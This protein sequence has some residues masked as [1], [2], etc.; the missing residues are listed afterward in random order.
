MDLTNEAAVGGS[1][2]T[3]IAVAPAPHGEMSL[4]AREAARNLAKWR[5]NREKQGLPQASQ[6]TEEGEGGEL[7]SCA[8]EA[9]EHTDAGEHGASIEETAITEQADGSLRIEPPSSWSEQDKELFVSLPRA[10]QERLAE[11]ECSRASEL[12][13]QRN[14]VEAD[15]A[16]L[17]EARQQYE[18]T[19]P[20][21]LASLQGQQ[22]SEFSDI[23]TPA[24]IER[25]AREDQPRF[26][27]WNLHQQQVA[28]VTRQ[29]LGAQ[30]RQASE[31]QR[32][33][34]DFAKRQDDL[35]KDKVPQMADPAEVAKLQSAA[36][37]VL[38]DHGFEEA[39][40]AASWHGQKDFSLRDHR[41]QLLVRDAILWREAKAKAKAAVAKPLPPVQRPGT[42]Q[43]KGA[44][45]EA[46]I[47]NL[48]KKLDASGSL[49]DAAALLKAR[50]ASR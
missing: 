3:A 26:A 8:P 24:D 4:D 15:R 5:H 34:A 14:A 9:L 41:V 2:P 6:H 19:L 12:A 29:I 1:E 16:K 50:R 39:E 21:L 47:Q 37:A 17:D 18:A 43:P 10:A 44:A 30:A 33:F 48:T 11:R 40:L 7:P 46:V 36:M 32:R 49:K 42:S 38:K 31:Q 20:Q 23:K 28:E 27:K 45:Q 35:F 22:A 25:L 13:E